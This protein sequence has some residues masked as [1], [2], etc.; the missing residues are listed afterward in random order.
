MR[1][2][3]NLSNGT[4]K[5]LVIKINTKVTYFKTLKFNW[6]LNNLIKLILR[7]APQQLSNSKNVLMFL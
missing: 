1:K 2:F 3:H 5:N 7:K 4:T 6:M